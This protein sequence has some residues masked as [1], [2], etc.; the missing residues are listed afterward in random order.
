M[1]TT[2]ST[3]NSTNQC[4]NAALMQQNTSVE[5]NVRFNTDVI[6][7][8]NFSASKKNISNQCISDGATKQTSNSV[9]INSDNNRTTVEST[10]ICDI[11]SD[12]NEVNHFKPTPEMFELAKKIEHGI[13]LL[14]SHHGHNN[15]LYTDNFSMSR[16]IK[17]SDLSNAVPCSWSIKYGDWVPYEWTNDP[18]FHSIKPTIGIGTLQS[19]IKK[20][21]FLLGI[22]ARPVRNVTELDDGA[23]GHIYLPYDYT[24]FRQASG[25]VTCIGFSEDHEDV[26]CMG[27]CDPHGW[28]GHVV[29]D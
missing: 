1:S 16:P 26:R 2:T 7:L 3:N 12:I 28:W 17:E 6:V 14:H 11:Y 19:L 24:K 20:C 18:E 5:N 23:G 29:N 25:I 27:W 8:D 9:G 10:T 15:L 13:T 21:G 4:N 22:T